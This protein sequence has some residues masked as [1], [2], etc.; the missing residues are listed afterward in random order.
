MRRSKFSFNTRLNI[1]MI[2]VNLFLIYY[3]VF[4][5]LGMSTMKENKEKEVVGEENRPKTQA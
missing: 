3:F 4:L 5:V 2:L 1:C